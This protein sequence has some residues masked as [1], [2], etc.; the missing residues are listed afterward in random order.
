[1][2]SLGVQWYWQLDPDNYPEV[3]QSKSIFGYREM[4]NLY[5]LV[6]VYHGS[7][8]YIQYMEKNHNKMQM[9]SDILKIFEYVSE[10]DQWYWI[11]YYNQSRL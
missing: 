2:L 4:S 7:E 11:C 10:S 5:L 6:G 8:C 3:D 1:M 9:L